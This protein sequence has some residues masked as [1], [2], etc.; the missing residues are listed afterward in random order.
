MTEETVSTPEQPTFQ[1]NVAWFFTLLLIILVACLPGF[2]CS[3][4]YL[5][6]VPDVTW[7]RGREDLTIDRIWMARL[8]GP[9]GIGLESQRVTDR[10]N[11]TQICVATNVRYLLWRDPDNE[12]LENAK[13]SRI[14]HL[15]D[16]GWQMTADTCE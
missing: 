14:Y 1:E 16:Q 11:E 5:S 4:F 10:I 3:L 15:T 13:Y 8:R 9:V 2:L 12:S 6:T 7:Q